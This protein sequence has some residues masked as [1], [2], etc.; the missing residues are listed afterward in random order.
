MTKNF[1]L[2]GTVGHFRFL[3]KTLQPLAYKK[4]KS[5]SELDLKTSALFCYHVEYYELKYVNGI[6][7]E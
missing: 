3:W 4:T 2:S 1:H 6:I 7:K 5:T